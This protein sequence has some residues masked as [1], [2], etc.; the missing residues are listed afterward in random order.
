MKGNDE[1]YNEQM[2]RF[3]VKWEAPDLWC[4]AIIERTIE[5]MRTVQEMLYS[6]R[7]RIRE[8]PASGKL[9]DCEFLNCERPN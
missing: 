8:I 2:R 1:L 6:G 3:R 4:V 7:Y 5:H 9:D